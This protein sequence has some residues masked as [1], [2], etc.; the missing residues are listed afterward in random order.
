MRSP[1]TFDPVAYLEN[2]DA[3]LRRCAAEHWYADGMDLAGESMPWVL[4]H[5]GVH[6]VLRD[7]R[8]TPRSFVDDMLA[9]GLSERT[10]YQ[11][12]PLFRRDGDEH[13][14]HRALLASAFSPR[15]VER[16][17]PTAAAVAA[18]LADEIVA[19]DGRCRFV[20]AFAGPLPP[21]VFAVLF[22]L[23]IEDRTRVASWAA[24]VTQAFLPGM[25]PEI[26]ASIESAASELRAYCDELIA[27][28]RRGPADDLI[29]GLIEAEVDGERLDDVDINDTMSG[30][31]FA[32]AETTRRQITAMMLA[33]APCPDAW[34]RVAG[35]VSRIPGAVEEVLRHRPIVPALTRVAVEPFSHE[36]L[37][38]PVGDRLLASFTTANHD[39]AVFTHPDD[40]DIDRSNAGDHVTF[41]WGPHF[42][43]GAGLARVELQESL[44]ALTERFGPPEIVDVAAT[45]GMVAPDEVELIFGRR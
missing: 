37:E 33:F 9:S 34:R 36:D 26:V 6:T 40:F 10:T 44:R 15:S 39:P 14:R 5:H 38:V 32:G 29:T 4:D 3:E 16:L 12:T 18:R 23:P 7:R 22:G 28:R 41:G 30:F 42:C 8:L 45:T 19:A 11:L 17:R 21:E 35:D 31:I 27:V 25:S 2:P 43:L 13:R 20:E 24:A 1:A